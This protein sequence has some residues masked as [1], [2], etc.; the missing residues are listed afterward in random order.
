MSRSGECAY[1]PSPLIMKRTLL[2]FTILSIIAFTGCSKEDEDNIKLATPSEIRLNFEDEFQIEATSTTQITYETDDKFHSVVSKDGLISAR[3]VGENYIKLT[4]ATGSTDIKVIIEPE[5]TLYETPSTDWGASK[6]DI[7]DKYGRPDQ[8]YKNTIGYNSYSNKA[9]L[10]IFEFD[11]NNK[12]R[13][14][15]VMVKTSYGTDLSKFLDERYMYYGTNDTSTMR[16]NSIDLFSATT[17]VISILL[18]EIYWQVIYIPNEVSRSNSTQR[19]D[20]INMMYKL[21]TK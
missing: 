11:E 14:S 2:S 16:I 20:Q 9:D 10:L 17:S 1:K 19:N 7:T 6:I 5:Y 3:F 8:T 13:A 21:L 12:L 18:D 4:N 15:A